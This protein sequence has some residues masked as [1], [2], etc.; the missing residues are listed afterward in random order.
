[1]NI[2]WNKKAFTFVEL[3]VVIV[4]LTIIWVIW[5]YTLTKHIE[6]ARDSSKI[7]ALNNIKTT[8]VNYKI[9][10]WFYPNPT[11]HVNVTYSWA[12]VWSQWTFWKDVSE[13]VNWSKEKILD[14]YTNNEYAYSITS[15]KKEF[16]LAWVLEN[17]GK[18]TSYNNILISS[19]FAAGNTRKGKATVLWDYNWN[20]IV[21]NIAWINNILSIPSI[22]ATNLSSTNLVDI[23]NN[24]RLVYNGWSN[25]PSNYKTSVFNVNGWEKFS[26]NKLVIFSWN[27]ST[28]RKEK[29]RL[30]LLL[31]LKRSYNWTKV[32]NSKWRY[33]K[34]INIDLVH[35]SGRALAL[36][37]DLV[38]F[39]LNYPIKCNNESFFAVPVVNNTGL[40]N[41]DFSGLLSQKV[42]SV[43][44]D[45]A[46]IAWFGTNKG[47][48]KYSWWNWT[49]YTKSN[50]LVNNNVTN[51][52]Q[53]PNGNIWVW[54]KGWISVLNKTSWNWTSYIKSN[55][56]VSNNIKAITNTSKGIFVTTDK[57]ISVFNQATLQFTPYTNVLSST[58]INKVIEV[59]NWNV[60]VATD[61]WVSVFDWTN[62][63]SYVDQLV[64]TNVSNITQVSGGN[65][66]VAT[67]EWISVFNWDNW[68]K[69]KDELISKEVNDI[70]QSNDNKIW[71]AT[72]KWVSLFDWTSWNE[73]A[74]SDWLISEEIKSI[75]Q[76]T[77][78]NM[79]FITKKGLSKLVN[80]KF[81][82]YPNN[83]GEDNNSDN[84]HDWVAGGVYVVYKSTWVTVIGIKN[85]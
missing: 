47:L 56:L 78:N 42:S 46:W 70:F 48:S 79:W 69:Y 52:T 68:S 35:P 44:V 59:S 12:T 32:N 24:N 3:M 66:W 37:C 77:D 18:N 82:N 36:A 22:I 65:I 2:H 43:I 83:S 30:K 40:N 4:I 26:S 33:L 53:T 9:N 17:N 19:S 25:L 72:E 38:Q 29:N 58:D 20:I 10:K 1:M 84:N 41:I 61:D 63:N 14:P 28:L 15:N 16:Q 51:V 75:F 81:I 49:S 27:L 76:D 23:I 50:W 64:G 45:S 74:V 31:Q 55:W 57:G 7:T 67:D 13:K 21:V 62:W 34:D 71:V 8:L 73:Y 60:W 85:N 54:T 6:W 80:W 39:E 11:N 5:F